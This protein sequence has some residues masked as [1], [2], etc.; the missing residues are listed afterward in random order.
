[1]RSYLAVGSVQDQITFSPQKNRSRVRLKVYRDHLFEEVSMVSVRFQT[2]S[3]EVCLWW[4]HDPTSNRPNCQIAAHFWTKPAAV[5]KQND[6]LYSAPFKPWLTCRVLHSHNTHKHCSCLHCAVNL[7]FIYRL[8]CLWGDLPKDKAC[9]FWTYIV[10]EFSAY[11]LDFAPLCL[12]VLLSFS[13][14]WI[15]INWSAVMEICSRHIWPKSN[16]DVVTWLYFVSF[17]QLINWF[18]P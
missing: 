17:H 7:L 1:M 2:N 14:T 16:V 15:L 11:Q 6:Y 10:S 13:R 3:G 4:E 5:V 18:R 12:L 9:W 8:S